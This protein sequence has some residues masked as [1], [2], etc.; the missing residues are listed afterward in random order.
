MNIHTR[1]TLK[2]D[3]YLIFKYTKIML[4]DFAHKITFFEYQQKNDIKTEI[5]KSKF[6]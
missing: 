4:R 6:E 2:I 5:K 1:D 3:L